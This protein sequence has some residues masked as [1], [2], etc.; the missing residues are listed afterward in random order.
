MCYIQFKILVSSKIYLDANSS[1][2]LYLRPSEQNC[3]CHCDKIQSQAGGLQLI[4]KINEKL[5]QCLQ[6]TLLFKGKNHP[7]V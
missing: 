7:D 4:E 3:G 2:E 6:I 5:L 1:G